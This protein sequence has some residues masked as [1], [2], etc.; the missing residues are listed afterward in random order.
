MRKEELLTTCFGLGKLPIAP[1]TWGSLPP[2][3]LY[4]V[5]RYVPG[6]FYPWITPVVMAALF[7]AFSWICVRFSPAII[8]ATGKKDP[9]MIVADEVAGQAVTM[10]IISL[11]WPGNICNTTVLGFFLFRLFDITKPWPC[12]RLEKLPAGAGILA[13]DL[14]AGVYGGIVAAIGIYY[15]PVC[16]G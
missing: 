8:A 16:F 9:Q 11:L 5:L 6:E 10:L 12:R 7:V 14:M 13:D 3:V 1:G 2:V 15:M 4:Q